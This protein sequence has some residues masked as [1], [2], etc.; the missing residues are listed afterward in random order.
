MKII[1]VL[2]RIFEYHLQPCCVLAEAFKDWFVILGGNIFLSPC[3]YQDGRL[4]CIQYC[5]FCGKKTE[6]IEESAN[7]AV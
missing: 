3:Q 6:E 1:K 5:P 4:L 2:N 7:N